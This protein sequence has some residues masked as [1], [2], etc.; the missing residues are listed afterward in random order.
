MHDTILW[1][2]LSEDL[3]E[4]GYHFVHRFLSEILLF[5]FLI[6]WRLRACFIYLP[7]QHDRCKQ[8]EEL[9]GSHIFSAGK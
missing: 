7:L 9:S 4:H 6:Y 8:A 5:D 1:C 3:T 2:A